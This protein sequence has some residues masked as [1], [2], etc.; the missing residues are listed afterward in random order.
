MAGLFE[1]IMTARRLLDARGAA[2]ETPACLGALRRGAT[3]LPALHHCSFPKVACA[4]PLRPEV[5]A[6]RR[7]SAAMPSHAPHRAVRLRPQEARPNGTGFDRH[8]VSVNHFTDQWTSGKD[9]WK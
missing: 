1:H 7:T 9:E 4:P 8:F 6:W 2:I 3:T 5:R